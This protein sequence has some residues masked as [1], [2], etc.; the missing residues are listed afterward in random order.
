MW[1]YLKQMFWGG[2]DDERRHET[3]GHENARMLE[4]DEPMAG[5]GGLL[6]GEHVK[7]ETERNLQ[8]DTQRSGDHGNGQ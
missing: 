8:E 6:A 1:N 5:A 7:S 2:Q 4:M 3:P